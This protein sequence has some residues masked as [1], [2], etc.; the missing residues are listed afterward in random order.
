MAVQHLP[1]NGIRLCADVTGN[2]AGLPLVLIHALGLDKSSWDGIAPAFAGT[3]HAY[4]ADMR[5]FGASA[6]VRDGRLREIPVGHHIHEE[7]PDEFLAAV[8]PFLSAGS[9]A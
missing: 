4:A 5:G 1:A 6:L 3:H 9:P 2:P 7:A 8:V